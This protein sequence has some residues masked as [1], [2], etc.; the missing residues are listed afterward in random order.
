MQ[1][2]E[3]GPVPCMHNGRLASPTF[4]PRIFWNWA[5]AQVF[6]MCHAQRSIRSFFLLLGEKTFCPGH[7]LLS[8]GKTLFYAA[9]R[10]KSCHLKLK[11][12]DLSVTIVR[13]N[14][15]LFLAGV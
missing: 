1:A 7:F 4:D 12:P 5:Y 10:K 8:I 11:I 15:S 3:R 2:D 14:I 9:V 13:K 6:L